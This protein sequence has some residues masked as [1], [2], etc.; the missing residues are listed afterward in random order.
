MF[1]FI[2]LPLETKIRVGNVIFLFT[3]NDRLGKRQRDIRLNSLKKLASAI[4][5][6]HVLMKDT[7]HRFTYANFFYLMRMKAI[8]L[9]YLRILFHKIK[10][11]RY[12][13]MAGCFAFLYLVQYSI[14][15]VSNR[16]QCLSKASRK[17]I[18]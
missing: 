6:Y 3:P 10:P 7:G 16:F 5:I 15:S 13:P 12:L 18:Q 1:F 9:Y 11:R 17:A 14:T 4:Q 2:V 8:R